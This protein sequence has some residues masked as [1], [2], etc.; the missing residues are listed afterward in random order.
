MADIRI[1]HGGRYIY[2]KLCSLLD[3]T[4]SFGPDGWHPRFFKEAAFISH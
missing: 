3:I 2:S 1:L 4:I